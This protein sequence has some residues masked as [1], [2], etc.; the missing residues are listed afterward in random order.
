MPRDPAKTATGYY[1]P[2]LAFTP[3][4]EVVADL[5]LGDQGAMKSFRVM[6]YAIFTRSQC[7]NRNL[8]HPRNYVLYR[9]PPSYFML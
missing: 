6:S 9:Y 8:I 3:P 4:S 1:P 7:I 2:S 5:L